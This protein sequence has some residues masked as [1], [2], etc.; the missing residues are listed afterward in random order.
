MQKTLNILKQILYKSPWIFLIILSIYLGLQFYLLFGHPSNE[1]YRYLPYI[2]Q[3]TTWVGFI[4]KCFIFMA[5]CLWV[6]TILRRLPKAPKYPNGMLCHNTYMVIPIMVCVLVCM[7]HPIGLLILGIVCLFE[8]WGVRFV[9]EFLNEIDIP[10]KD[11]REKYFKNVVN[12]R[13]VEEFEYDEDYEDG[14]DEPNYVPHIDLAR[15]QNEV[16]KLKQQPK[17]Y[18]YKDPNEGYYQN[19]EKQRILEQQKE[20]ERKQ[21]EAEEVAYLQNRKMEEAERERKSKTIRMITQMNYNTLRIEYESGNCKTFNGEL[22]TYSPSSFTLNRDGYQ[23]TYDSTC[24]LRYKRK[25]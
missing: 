4:G 13:I 16:Y 17:E 21:R 19:R 7:F 6:F 8:I 14:D 9:Y 15:L 1:M 23:Y 11:E 12:P 2:F 25:L 24:S 22:V 3:H 18:V 20:F 5:F 10:T